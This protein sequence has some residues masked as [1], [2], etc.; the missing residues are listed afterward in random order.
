MD[1]DD[2]TLYDVE[3]TILGFVPLLRQRYTQAQFKEELLDSLLRDSL[4]SRA[5]RDEN[6]QSIPEVQKEIDEAIRR[7]LAKVYEKRIL[8]GSIS[9][10]EM[11]S[12]YEKNIDQYKTP[13]Q[14]RGRRIL[15][16]TKA[17]AEEILKLLKDGADFNHLAM[18]RSIDSAGKQ[19]GIF[20]WLRTGQMP[21]PIEKVAFALEEGEVSEVIATPS[22]YF[23]IKVE[24]KRVGK[25][26]P[27]SEVKDRVRNQ[28]RS[29]KQ[30]MAV[31]TKTK[32]L[33]EKYQARLHLEFLSEVPVPVGE[34]SDPTRDMDSIQ[35][36][37]QILKKAMERPY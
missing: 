7:T 34:K 1:E 12:Y 20:G 33:K 23:L 27:F 29:D 16:K 25:Q 17:E 28:L 2:I 6:L 10:K 21:P 3:S 11:L 26:L 4:Y 24:E 14:I 15:V 30:R 31:E 13:E 35:M 37:Q 5:A 36:L 32:E 18:E 22:G 19:G 8:S 9:E